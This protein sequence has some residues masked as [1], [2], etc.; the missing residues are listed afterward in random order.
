M[1]RF[2]PLLVV[3]AFAS[4]AFGCA[5]NDFYRGRVTAQGGAQAQA[6]HVKDG[7]EQSITNRYTVTGEGTA[8]VQTVK[9]YLTLEGA[10]APD[11]TPGAA[12]KAEQPGAVVIRPTGAPAAAPAPRKPVCTGPECAAPGA[13]AADECKPVYRGCDGTPGG[14]RPA[15]VGML[16]EPIEPGTGWP[17]GDNGPVVNGVMGAVVL[18][19]GL[20]IHTVGCLVQ[21]GKCFASFFIP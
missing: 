18:P 3:L 11:V 10:W 7:V 5:S 1:R 19:P 15:P 6:F 21:F 9:P 20:V 16:D 8:T 17:C 13:A 2:L 12:P 14:T 4:V